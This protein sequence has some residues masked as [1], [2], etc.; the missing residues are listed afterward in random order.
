M[1]TCC[2]FVRR[3]RRCVVPAHRCSALTR[4]RP[5][6]DARMP[7]LGRLAGGGLSL[8]PG[9]LTVYISFNGGGFFV[10]TTPLVA[11]IMAGR[12]GPP[13]PL[14]PH[15]LPPHHPPPSP[16]PGALGPPAPVGPLSPRSVGPPAPARPPPPPP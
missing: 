10:G 7:V 4:R 1:S 6:Y 11:A 5:S 8:L 13:P 12:P 2:G 15:P 3:R 9:A 16:P 14:P